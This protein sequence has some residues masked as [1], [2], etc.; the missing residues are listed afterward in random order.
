[1]VKLG[2]G[3]EE[4]RTPCRF[5][6]IPAGPAGTSL[7]SG[8]RPS[9]QL[10]TDP[11]RSP[12]SSKVTMR[13]VRFRDTGDF[14]LGTQYSQLKIDEIKYTNTSCELGWLRLAIFR[15][16]F[17][18]ITVPTN[19]LLT[20]WSTFPVSASSRFAA[21]GSTNFPNFVIT[22]F[23]SALVVQIRES[24]G[25]LLRDYLLQTFLLNV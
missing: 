12:T 9:I 16:L 25:I 11:W 18:P 14:C 17:L 4:M 20:S 19:L 3:Y 15:A 24:S 10:H 13:L 6:P 1:M 22:P 5:W 21:D 23:S 2:V 7:T 8:F